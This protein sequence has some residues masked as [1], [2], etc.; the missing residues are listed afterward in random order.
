MRRSTPTPPSDHHLTDTI[1]SPPPRLIGRLIAAVLIAD[2]VYVWTFHDVQHDFD[3]GDATCTG[4]GWGCTLS[5]GTQ[6]GL[7]AGAVFVVAFVIALMAKDPARPSP[8]NQVELTRARRSRGTLSSR[9]RHDPPIEH[10]HPLFNGV[11]ALVDV[12]DLDGVLAAVTLEQVAVAWSCYGSRQPETDDDPDWW[13]IQ[14]W[15]ELAYDREDVL[16]EGL[17]ALIEVAP[18]ELLGLVG[19]GPLENFVCDDASRLTW[20]EAQAARSPR[21]RTALQGVWWSDLPNTVTS[22]IEAARA[23]G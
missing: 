12:G 15:F 23:G 14:F 10:D 22:R 21:F 7:W 9:A 19:A 16:R 8:D 13:A 2:L 1:N 20:L 17:L 4:I 6:A 18:D 5:P 11:Q 3:A